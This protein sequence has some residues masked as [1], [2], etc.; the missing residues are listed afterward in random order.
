MSND[1]GRPERYG[2]YRSG[3][4]EVGWG[5]KRVGSLWEEI[6]RIGRW[7]N[8]PAGKGGRFGRPEERR[9]RIILKGEPV[10][11]KDF[12]KMARRLFFFKLWS[13]ENGKE[14]GVT[15][16]GRSG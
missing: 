1:P 13:V 7:G 15:A 5:D 8:G 4:C 3:P 14:G 2:R 11:H 10:C 16:R 6:G 12:I 9:D